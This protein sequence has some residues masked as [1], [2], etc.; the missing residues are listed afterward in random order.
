[1][2]GNDVN[3]Q[4]VRDGFAWHFK[5]FSKDPALAKAEAAAKS[6]KLGLWIDPAP[7]PP[8]DFRAPKAGR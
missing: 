7:V 1:M 3:L 5:K 4:M 2:A 6:A 8:W